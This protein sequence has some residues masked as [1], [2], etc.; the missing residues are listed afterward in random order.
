MSPAHPTGAVAIIRQLPACISGRQP[1]KQAKEIL[2][3][4]GIPSFPQRGIGLKTDLHSQT[5]SLMTLTFV[6]PH[7]WESCVAKKGTSR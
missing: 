7:L 2:P 4:Q 6:G 3:M 5:N 1:K